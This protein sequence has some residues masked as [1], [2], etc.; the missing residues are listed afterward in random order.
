MNNY[1]TS[2]SDND[3]PVVRVADVSKWYSMWSTP[4]ARLAHPFLQLAKR[5]L[6]LPG[7]SHRIDART[8]GMYRQ[9]HALE[10]VSLEIRKGESWGFIGVNGS[11]KSTLLKII[12]GNL[13]PSSGSVEV[14]GKVAI[15]DY[16][17]G[18]SGEFTGRENVYL[19]A[20]ILG[21]TRRQ[22]DERFDSIAAFADIGD[23]MDQPV[24]TYS[25]GM[26]AR[27]GFAIM[28]HVDADIMITDEALAVGDAFFVQKCM[29]HIRRFLEQGTFLFVTHSI[30]DVVALCNKAVWLEHGRVRE[31]GAAKDVADAYLSSAS[32]QGSER[33]LSTSKTRIKPASLPES[34]SVIGNHTIGQPAL[35]TLTHAKRPRVVRDPRQELIDKSTLRNDI[36]IPAFSDNPQE[37]FGVGGARIVDVAFE[38]ENGGALSWII[39]AEM[40]RLRIAVRVDHDMSSPIVGFQV[41]DRLG[42]TL[43]A[44]N[45]YLITLEKP[46]VAEA[47]RTF[48]AEFCFQMPML[49]AGDYV[50]RPA[51]ALGSESDH[52]MLHCID[53]GLLFRSVTSA[54]RH[55][56]VGVPMQHIGI[57]LH[58][59]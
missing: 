57:Q 22:I 55:G 32:L 30:N 1:T 25:S 4:H 24:K 33:F 9:F 53:N 42:Q 27:L 15:L 48:V 38:D 37:G 41:K 16:G 56:L 44:D 2:D 18:I 14:E 10:N 47:G 49:P 11:G 7:V 40:V 8:H 34:T 28:A 45:T 51:V 21:L 50:I 39:G 19:K 54:V 52:A 5:V 58:Q 20:S 17:S 6:P 31:I 35:A 36:E 29:A 43:F 12:S 13:R 23:F 3:L 46:F 26:G 59:E